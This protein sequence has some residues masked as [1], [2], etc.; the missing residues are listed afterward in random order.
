MRSVTLVA[1]TCDPSSFGFLDTPGTITFTT[2]PDCTA[3][4]TLPTTPTP[5]SLP[6]EIGPSHPLFL[7]SRPVQLGACGIG[8]IVNLDPAYKLLSITEG[9]AEGNCQID[10]VAGDVE[11]PNGAHD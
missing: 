4:L 10:Y 11:G 9:C 3:T 1:S 7:D 6:M 8:V 5:M 2:N